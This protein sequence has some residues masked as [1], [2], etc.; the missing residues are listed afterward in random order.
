MIGFSVKPVDGETEIYGKKASEL[1]SN[2]IV[3][4][5]EI[6]G[7]LHYV[8][9]YTEFSG[10]EEKQSG[11]YL[12]FVVEPVPDDATVTVEFVGANTTIGPVELEPDDRSLVFRITD[13]STQSIKITTKSGKSSTTKTYALSGLTL[14][15]E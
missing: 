7:T 11:N 15:S 13:K 6:T 10:D 1:Q 2:V 12:A 8:T 9:G 5:S 14:E 3:S 4:D